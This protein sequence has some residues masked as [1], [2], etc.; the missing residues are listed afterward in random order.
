MSD[1]SKIRQYE[2]ELRRLKAK[3]SLQQHAL[4]NKQ[5]LIA[6]K[7]EVRRRRYAG[8]YQGASALGSTLK[9]GASNLSHFAK[10]RQI[11]QP[12]KR[13]SKSYGNSLVDWDSI[14]GGW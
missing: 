13:R 2:E 6:L 9:R 8:L 3:E 12:K 14:G 7:Q 4:S 1:I 5:K 10:T 11:T